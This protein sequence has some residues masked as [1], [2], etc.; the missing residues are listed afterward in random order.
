MTS[1]LSE[2]LEELRSKSN[3]PFAFAW[4]NKFSMAPTKDFFSLTTLG[5]EDKVLTSFEAIATEAERARVHGFTAT[6]FDRQKKELMRSLERQFEERDKT[7]SNRLVWQYVGHALDQGFLPG[8]EEQLGLTQRLL[9]S[10]R[11]D[12]INRLAAD[13]I[14][15][16]N[17]VITVQAPMN[18]KVTMPT[19]DELIA[20]LQRIESE[21]LVAY[22]DDVSDGPLMNAAMTPGTVVKESQNDKL[23]LVEWKLSNGV[24]VIV[25][26]T[27][28]K[29]D[30]IVMRAYSP[31][32]TSLISD[33]AMYDAVS[34]ASGAIGQSGVGEFSQTALVKKLAGKVAFVS[35]NI[36]TLNEGLYGGGSSRDIETVL[37]L[38]NMFFTAPRADTG[39]FQAY[40]TLMSTFAKNRGAS[41]EGRMQDTIG[42]T[43]AQ[44]HPRSKPFSQA[45]LDAMDLK[46]SYDF[47]RDRF[48]DAG[49][50]TFVFVGNLDMNT[51][52]PMV[53]EYL[54]SLPSKGRVENW[55][56]IGVRYPTGKIEKSV[57][58]GVEPKSS[59]RTVITGRF[60]WSDRNRHLLA[61]TAGVLRIM[62]REILREELGGTY[63]VMVNANAMHQP[64]DAYRIDI[65]F[66]CAPERVAELSKAMH[67][68]LD[69]LKRFGPSESN[70]TKI[71][72]SQRRDRET[73]LKENNYWADQIEMAVRNGDDPMAILEEDEM[74]DE[75]TAAAIK[76]A[77]NKYFDLTNSV[78]VVLYPETTVAGEKVN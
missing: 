43:L 33:D 75:L 51:F 1:L 9:P 68:T 44:Y 50:F 18:N 63:G 78:R 77:A 53:E 29:N 64:V 61:S 32:G 24:R 72:E 55:R 41:P 23:G 62:L 31:G 36:G 57:S 21:S 65:G 27:T 6:E 40:K 35:P 58:A 46:K 52:K 14:T 60:D 38:T 70:L 30:E 34:G 12:E 56:D 48:S 7:E 13:M 59:V 47:Y 39:S 4:G 37:Q 22:R 2:R 17:R 26:P 76:E 25:K 49:D 45:T 8:I 42:V 73:K 67:A 66:G 69:S 74:T 19:A 28:F 71:K 16:E 3:P 20:V 54:G 5:P 10:I 11:L 15:R